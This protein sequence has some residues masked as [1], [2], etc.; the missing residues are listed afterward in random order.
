MTNN[1]IIF[2]ERCRL[3]KE[4]VIGTTGR[5]VLVPL[6]DG[7]KV[8]IWEPAELHTF[9]AWKEL[10]FIVKK[11]EHARAKIRIWKYTDGRKSTDAETAADADGEDHG[12]MFMKTA[13]FFS[14]SQ[15]EPLQKKEA[16]V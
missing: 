10:G 8:E 9:A 15:V 12:H 2:A 3:M 6:Q 7:R 14:P 4:G 11:G 16:A 5:K 13:F 1:Q